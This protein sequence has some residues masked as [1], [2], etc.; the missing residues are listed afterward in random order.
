VLL[1]DNT[2]ATHLYR[3]AQEAVS[4]AVKHGRAK[5]VK[6][7]LAGGSNQLR[8][9]IQDDGVGFPEELD[10]ETR[11]MGVRIMHYRARIIGA[12]LEISGALDGGT[13]LTCT[14]RNLDRPVPVGG[15]EY[16]KVG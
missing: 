13:T 6:V 9:R 1:H 2:I 3:I 16:G 12:N 8:L 7:S 15:E 11:G 5:T 10:E 14:L 4:N